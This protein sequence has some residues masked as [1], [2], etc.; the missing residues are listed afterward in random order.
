MLVFIDSKQRQVTNF[1]TYPFYL[2]DQGPTL[3]LTDNVS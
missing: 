1:V 2:T 3:F